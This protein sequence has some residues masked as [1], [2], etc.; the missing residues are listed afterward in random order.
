[1][2]QTM[3]FKKAQIKN[4][5]DYLCFNHNTQVNL[6]F[7]FHN[8]CYQFE[9]KVIM[10]SLLDLKNE[11]IEELLWT[12]AHEFRHHLQYEGKVSAEIQ[13]HYLTKLNKF[14]QCK[15]SIKLNSYSLTII[16]FL[17]L[18]FKEF[19]LLMLLINLPILTILVFFIN[20]PGVD[21][22]IWLSHRSNL[23]FEKMIE[24]DADNFANLE[25][26]TG[27]LVWGRY[28]DDDDFDEEK[29]QHPSHKERYLESLKFTVN[30]QIS[31][32]LK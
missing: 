2:N 4:F 6:E 5:L 25:V 7:G 28:K 14:Q 13:N 23:E 22:Y 11:T 18:A 27:V 21:L 1:M 31:Q 16:P 20:K 26:G 3:D 15:D 30:P 29:T 24:K 8:A 19:P 12:L 9:E 10:F 32:F 17:L